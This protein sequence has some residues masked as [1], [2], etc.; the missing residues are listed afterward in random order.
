MTLAMHLPHVHIPHAH[1]PHAHLPQLHLPLVL[2]KAADDGGERVP[3]VY[4][5]RYTFM[6]NAAMS[7]AMDRL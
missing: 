1:L 6:E 5:R 4:P 3:H 7:R 2:H